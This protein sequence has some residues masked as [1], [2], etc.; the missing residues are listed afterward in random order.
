MHDDAVEGK[1]NATSHS[2]NDVHMLKLINKLQDKIEKMNAKLDSQ[3]N[4]PPRK[5]GNNGKGNRKHKTP[6]D[7]SKRNNKFKYFWTHGAC[8][9]DS[10][11]CKVK[12]PRHK[13]DA[14]HDNKQG[15]SLAFCN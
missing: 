8:G 5:N 13:D 9:H 15:G 1:A 12:A 2:S 14:T 11:D 6:D 7:A 3:T 10:P 4:T